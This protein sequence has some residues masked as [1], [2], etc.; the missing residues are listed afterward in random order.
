MNVLVTGIASSTI[1][2]NVYASESTGKE[3]GGE[4]QTA[5]GRK[6]LYSHN[7]ERTKE[8]TLIIQRS[9]SKKSEYNDSNLPACRLNAGTPE[10]AIDQSSK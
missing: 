10:A 8:R 4:S 2:K 5:R 3:K 1:S 6:L 7:T 9:K